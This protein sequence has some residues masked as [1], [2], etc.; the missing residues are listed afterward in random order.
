[1]NVPAVTLYSTHSVSVKAFISLQK[2]VE[3][4]CLQCKG[5]RNSRMISPKSSE[6]WKWKNK[7]GRLKINQFS[8]RFKCLNEWPPGTS[9]ITKNENFQNDSQTS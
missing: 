2:V 3:N 8:Q 1:M 6:D 4:A 7:S 5:N 9:S